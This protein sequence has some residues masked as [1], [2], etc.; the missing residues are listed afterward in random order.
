MKEQSFVSM[1]A[2]NAWKDINPHI[3]VVSVEGGEY[4]A[5]YEISQRIPRERIKIKYIEFEED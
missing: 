3:Y 5:E 1:L 2:F 4:Y